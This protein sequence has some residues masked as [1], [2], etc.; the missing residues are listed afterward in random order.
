MIS[1]IIGWISLAMAVMTFAAAWRVNYDG[2]TLAARHYELVVCLFLICAA[3]CF[4]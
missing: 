3:I 2:N 4:K 1:Q